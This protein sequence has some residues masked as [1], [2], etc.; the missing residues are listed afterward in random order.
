MKTTKHK[1]IVELCGQ[2][3][4]F[5]QIRYFRPFR[6]MELKKERQFAA[7][8]HLNNYLILTYPNRL[9]H[10]C[11]HWIKFSWVFFFS[12]VKGNINK[13]I[14]LFVGMNLYYTQ[15]CTV[16]ICDIIYGY[17][18][19]EILPYFLKSPFNDKFIPAILS[20]STLISLV[21]HLRLVEV[22]RFRQ[23]RVLTLHSW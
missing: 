4:Y 8:L 12:N 1:L 5:G 14:D 3:L 11:S 16:Q 19:L 2:L 6:L 13:Q 23:S 18:I 17:D 22:W 10:F 15:T 9:P 20:V 7:S 21:L